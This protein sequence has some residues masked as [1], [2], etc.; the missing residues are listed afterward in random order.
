MKLHQVVPSVGL[1][2]C[3]ALLFPSERPLYSAFLLS[4]QELEKKVEEIQQAAA[5][6]PSE[7]R[8]ILEKRWTGFKKQ[9]ADANRNPQMPP[10]RWYEAMQLFLVQAQ[11]F[12]QGPDQIK[13]QKKQPENELRTALQN[14]NR[15]MDSL[16]QQFGKI[17][18]YME[19]QE[20]ARNLS[21]KLELI[22]FI[23]KLTRLKRIT[24]VQPR[25]E[26]S[27]TPEKS[28]WFLQVQFPFTWAEGNQMEDFSIL[29]DKSPRFYPRDMSHSQCFLESLYR[30]VTMQR[31]EASDNYTDYFPFKDAS[32]KVVLLFEGN[33]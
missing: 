24:Q 33:Q 7:Q 14:L 28:F 18:H 25:Y 13:L 9:L 27:E 26:F 11:R 22:P 10:L 17:Q 8:K 12:E 30:I 3:A 15:E 16:E 1:A 31:N 29:L 23:Q 6:K 20:A 2:L 21:Q 5:M 19:V 4:E 32:Y